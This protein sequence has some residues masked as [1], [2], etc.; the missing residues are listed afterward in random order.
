MNTFSMQ[1]YLTNPKAPDLYPPLI[2][3][4][5]LFFHSLQSGERQGR[6]KIQTKVEIKTCMIHSTVLMAFEIVVVQ[7]FLRKSS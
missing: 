3:S 2:T 4:I 6:T 5:Y 1:R 7:H